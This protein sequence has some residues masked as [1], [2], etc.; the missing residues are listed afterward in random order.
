MKMTNQQYSAY[1]DRISPKSRLWKNT[2]SAFLAGGII[3]AIGEGFIQVFAH[4]GMSV[5]DAH[6][7]AAVALIFI[8]ALLT[9]LKIYDNLARIGKAGV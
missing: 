7:M 3:C 8:G 4:F 1:I 9:G 2:I 6:V 5:K